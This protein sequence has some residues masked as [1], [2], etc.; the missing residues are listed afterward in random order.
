MQGPPEIFIMSSLFASLNVARQALQAQ[1]FGLDVTQN[2]ISNVNT[3]G[4]ARQRVNF[5][6]G[7]SVFQN[8]YAVGMGVRLGSVESFRSGL[9]DRRVNDELQAK[10]EFDASSAVL[11]QVEALFN[12]SGGLG[13]QTAVNDFFNSFS[14]LAA[15][16]EDISLREQVLARGQE[17][18][19]RFNQAY[20]KLQA[21]QSQQNGAVAETVGEINTTAAAIA[22]LNVEI[23]AA[24]GANTNETT[25]VDQRQEMLDK[26]A[27]LTDISYF[28]TDSGNV[29]V[30][31]PQGALLVTGDVSYSW[32]ASN[33][34]S[35]TMLGVYAGGVDITSRIQSGKLGGMLKAR[36]TNISGYLSALD[37]MAAGFISR[38]NLQHAAGSDLDGA[39][40]GDFFNVFVPLVPGTTTGAARAIGVAI[41]D[42]RKIAA[43]AV[44]SGQGSNANAQALA[45]LQEDPFLPGGATASQF[46]SNL[47]FRIG[48]DTKTAV[49]GLGVQKQLLTQLQ[50]QRDSVSGVSLDDEAVSMMQYQKAYAA[51]AR[52]I[53]VISELT[54]ILVKILGG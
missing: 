47:V 44:G 6:P 16:P 9:M 1:Q 19:T 32:S 43:A 34:P 37:D 5:V 40:G 30:M 12:E 41:S 29:T 23:Q 38:V 33:G 8:N 3:P 54:D 52:F 11:Q 18:G 49:D 35:G 17:L 4:Y 7:D 31:S 10:G 2:N 48:L 50:N 45:K 25:L 13:L 14:A 21:I 15:T 39:A 22:K 26:L 53:T 42:P 24:R 27:G 20:Q 46:Y 51:N 36:D 28:E